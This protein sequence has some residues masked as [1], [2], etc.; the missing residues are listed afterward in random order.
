MRYE[1]SLFFQ[2]TEALPTVND[3]N[4]QLFGVRVE[5]NYD[6]NCGVRRSK[7]DGVSD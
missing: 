1:K 5:L 3:F 2:F 6:L 4:G 7:L